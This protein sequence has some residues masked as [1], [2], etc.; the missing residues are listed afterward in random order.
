MANLERT[1]LNEAMLDRAMLDRALEMKDATC[2]SAQMRRI[3]MR[4]ESRERGFFKMC[5]FDAAMLEGRCR[6]G[7]RAFRDASRFRARALRQ[8]DLSYLELPMADFEGANLNGSYL[9]GT[10]MREANLREADLRSTGLAEVDLGGADLRNADFFA[11]LRFTWVR[12]APS[13]ERHPPFGRDADGV[14]HG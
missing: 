8:C 13:E 12:R 1:N 2:V 6:C 3:A 10:V 7:T 4:H 11:G 9:T 14:L 5:G